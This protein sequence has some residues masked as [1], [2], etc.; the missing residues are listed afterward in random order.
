VDEF[1]K[2]GYAQLPAKGKALRLNAAATAS[3]LRN[4]SLN[5]P[6]S[7]SVLFAV[8]SL[9]MY[10][11]RSKQLPLTPELPDPLTTITYGSWIS[12]SDEWAQELGVKDKDEVSFTINNQ[13]FKFPVKVQ[14]GL[15]GHVAT[16]HLEQIPANVLSRDAASGEV[17]AV[18]NNVKLEKTG[19]QVKIPILAGSMEEGEKRE[20]FPETYEDLEKELSHHTEVK[21]TLYPEHHHPVWPHVTLRIMCP[22]SA[23]R[24]T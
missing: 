18:I 3:L 1:L 19:A 8:P 21:A 22:W 14:P 13:Q 2:K 10:D 4:A 5:A 16:V 12:V 20:I 11:G 9:R 17:L 23:K 6:A 24:N 7:G 15:N